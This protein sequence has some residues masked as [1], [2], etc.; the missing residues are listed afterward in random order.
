MISRSLPKTTFPCSGIDKIRFVLNPLIV[1]TTKM[2][3]YP[4]FDHEKKIT[5]HTFGSFAYVE[6]HAEYFNPCINY[7]TQIANVITILAERGIIT[8]GTSFIEKYFIYEHIDYFVYYLA[9]LE[10][11]FDFIPQDI[12]IDPKEDDP[13]VSDDEKLLK[14]PFPTT[15]YTKGTKDNVGI[16]YDRYEKLKSTNQISHKKIESNPYRIRLEFR[17]SRD[18]CRFLSLRNIDGNY[19]Q[20]FQNYLH[21][22]SS[23]YTKHFRRSLDIADEK[24]PC[25]HELYQESLK[26][27]KRTRGKLQDGSITK[28]EKERKES[29]LLF[30]LATKIAK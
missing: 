23:L 24:Y 7:I 29:T 6:I 10:F 9:E 30:L 4:T 18:N 21:Y 14:K 28:E 17:L 20:I 1:N 27:Y 3:T 22:L 5:L 2:N 11:F 15:Y 8:W 13:E 19:Y 16:I 12:H 26:G 25:F